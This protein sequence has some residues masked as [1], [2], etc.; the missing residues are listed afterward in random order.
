MKS[1]YPLAMVALT[2]AL[3]GCSSDDNDNPYVKGD[4]DVKIAFSNPFINNSVKERTATPTS[5]ENLNEFR[6]WGFVVDPSS[7][8][9]DGNKVER[10]GDIWNVDR[11]EYW[12]A[13]Q[14]YWFSAIAP[15]DNKTYSFE[16][17]TTPAETY[18]GGGTLTFHNDR[19]NGETDLVYAFSGPIMHPDGATE[20]EPVALTFNHMLSQL[21]FRFI[22]SVSESTTLEVSNL[23]ITN[24]PSS[25]VIDLNQNGTNRLWTIDTD[26][27]FV[28]SGIDTEGRF[29][30]SSPGNSIESEQVYII[31]SNTAVKYQ[32]AFDID[33]YNGNNRMATYSHTIE[34]PAETEFAIGQSYRFTATF[35]GENVAPGGL[36]PIEFTVD[37]VNDWTMADGGEVS[38]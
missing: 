17:V 26:N 33:V 37:K 20:F 35:T 11:T 9:F 31:P 12:Y 10:A 3:A 22:N 8:V 38:Y 4:T 21:S 34:L 19:A 28:L 2:A 5:N 18:Y 24:V 1:I 25:G 29:G 36:K 27:S 23:R 30:Y 13:G 16:P 6:V 14:N 32:V 7:V 15:Y